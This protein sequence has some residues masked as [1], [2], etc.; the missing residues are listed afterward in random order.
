MENKRDFYE[1]LGVSRSASDPE[2]KKAY[3]RMAMK[4]HPDRNAG[5]KAAEEKFKEVKKAYEVL[6]NPQTRQAYDQFG[7]DAVN[8]AAQ[9]PGGGAGFGGFGDIFGDIFENIFTGGRPGGGQSH[10]QRGADLRYNLTIT[11]EEA[12][13]GTEVEIT[14]PTQVSCKTCGGSGAQ[15]GTQAVNCG[16]CQGA[17]QVKIQ[18]GFFTIQQTCPECHGEGKVIQSPCYD[19]RGQGRVED[20]KKLKVKIPAGVDNG[21]RIRLNGEGEMGLHSGPS[22]DL[23]VQV[24]IKSH[25]IFERRDNDLY[26]NVPISFVTAALGGELEVPTLSGRVTLKIPHETQSG[27][28]FRMRGKGIKSVRGYGVGDLLCKVVVETPVNLSKDQKKM[29]EGFEA[30]LK[31][32][33]KKHT[34]KSNTWFQCVK[35]FFEEMKFG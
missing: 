28:V 20:T 33:N 16:T 25:A 18:Q 6:S 12:A 26:C 3:R 34:P 9:G 27:K 23:Y 21:D 29:L 32:S 2:L 11:L 13:L 30:S 1:V 24:E 10:A 4:Y 8:G 19:C 31:D 15:K 7:H 5:D 22:G 14:V 17:G 35:K